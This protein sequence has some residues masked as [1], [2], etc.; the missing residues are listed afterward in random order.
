MIPLRSWFLGATLLGACSAPHAPSAPPREA[1]TFAIGPDEFLLDGQ[2]FVIRSGEMHAARVPP[3]Y[4][5]H[6]LRMV[7]AMG[8][9]TVCAYLFWNQHEPR[10][11]QFE[12]TGG[13]D[14]ARYCRIAQEEGLWVILRPGPYACAEWELGGFPWW[15]LKEP[16]IQLRTRDE[17]YLAA[18]RRYLKRVGDELAPLQ[19]TR[20]GP[21]L[22]AQVENEYGSYG[23][24]KEYI[25]NV[26]DALVAAGF[27]VPLFTCDGPSQLPND[28]RDDVFSVVNFG[29]DAKNSPEKSFEALRQVRSSGPLMCGE[30]YPGW[31]DSWGK[32]HHTG[33]I[34][35]ILADLDSMLS[36]RRSFS[37]YMA[38]GGTSFGFT[39]GANAPPFSPQSTSYDY[40]APIDES[41]RATPK[42]HAIRALFERHL[43]P[44]ETLTPE[45]D[46]NPV[47]AVP[48]FT[49]DEAAPLFAQAGPMQTS[50]MPR[51]FEEL[52]APQGC[53]L[54]RAELPAGGP[55]ELKITEVH[56]LAWV[57]LDGKRVDAFDRRSGRSTL[58]LG[59]R[60]NSATLELF[61]EAMGRVNYGGQIHDRKGITEKVEL[62]DDDGA[63]ALG[64]WQHHVYPFDKSH[65]ARIAYQPV[66]APIGAP[67]VYRGAFALAKVGDTFLDTRGWSKGAVWINGHALGRYWKI[68]PQ[69]TLYV[70]GCWLKK[71]ENIVLVLDVD[72]GTTTLALAGLDYPIL[73]QP[74]DDLAS[75]KKLRQKGQ[76]IVLDGRTP[77][78][79]ET[80][81]DGAKEQ[82]V[83][84]PACKG[85]Y[86]ALVAKNSQREDEFTTLAEL[87]LIGAN[88]VE[89]PRSSW[90]VT[91]ADSEEL[92][93]ENG[94]ALQVIDGDPKTIWHTQW[95]GAKPNHP[96][97]IV[98]DLGED[99]TITGL[100]CL[101]RQESANGRIRQWALYVSKQP[102]AGL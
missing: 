23:K 77:A 76:E 41:G 90:S 8:C 63:H 49:L 26:R 86:V 87:Y 56:D 99:Q 27:E 1:H 42:Y 66:S 58:K 9:N 78:A 52:D 74:A 40:D 101:P 17:R 12:F 96:H 94:S 25:G 85:R 18:V 22:M 57:Y 38:H 65:L 98:L 43:N 93:A 3:E 2:P 32:P 54:Y 88:G 67:A 50:A 37:I 95:S 44:G 5:R 16:G 47:V 82:K 92:D 68:G 7:R 84:F 39:A 51:T 69:Q 61:V 46:P 59:A 11:G 72:G 28:V 83:V 80:F 14:A 10:P 33:S 100:R 15:L 20:G 91:W 45:P 24:D 6:R 19:V 4:W 73:D 21:I 70:P 62:V 29:H 31:F 89:L 81:A 53:V 36:N 35:P 13:A 79:Q 48:R 102:F 55:A 30:Y 97:V 71:G 60:A 75:P 34:E 64:P